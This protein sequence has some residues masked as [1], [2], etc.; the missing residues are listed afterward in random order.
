[1]ATARD[2]MMYL[3]ARFPSER[4]MKLQ[5]LLYYVKAWS[6]VWDGQPLF[7]EPVQ[8]WRHGPVVPSMRHVMSLPA[9]AGRLTEREVDVVEA[10]LE[11]YGGMSASAL[12]GLTHAERPWIEAWEARPA[13]SDAGNAEIGA[14]SM[15]R[16]YGA[17][18]AEGRGPIPPAR[19][20]VEVA[21]DDDVAWYGFANAGRWKDALDLLGR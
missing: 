18:A 5:K 17:Q 15:M 21:R 1:M 3:H 2:V 9:D 8:A 16:F 6:L 12:R 11:Y 14:E 19:N 4:E 13:G 7:P 10:V 20:S